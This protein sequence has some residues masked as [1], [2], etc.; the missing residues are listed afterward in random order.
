MASFGDTDESLPVAEDPA[1]EEASSIVGGG[2]REEQGVVSPRS[3][4]D[5]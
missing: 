2:E 5:W 4:V 3:P 1:S